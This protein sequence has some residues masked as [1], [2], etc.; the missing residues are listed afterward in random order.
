MAPNTYIL[1]GKYSGNN[2]LF[3]FP[4]VWVKSQFYDYAD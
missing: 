3:W 4:D 2:R 1:M